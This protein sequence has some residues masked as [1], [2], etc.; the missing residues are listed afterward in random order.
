MTENYRR[1]SV[2]FVVTLFLVMGAIV[3]LADAQQNLKT[4]VTNAED[5]VY[6]TGALMI[7]DV[8]ARATPPRA[9][10]GAAYLTIRNIGPTDDVLI[11]VSSDIARKT[12]I[13]QS[14]LDGDIMKM[15]HV[16]KINVPANGQVVLKT[17]AQH[18]MFMGMKQP[19]TAGSSF[20]VVLVFEK[21]G[22]VAI[23]V[24]VRKNKTMQM[25]MKH[26]NMGH[27]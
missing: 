27:N 8:W 18:I 12:Q 7:S 2:C 3:P 19:L 16:R 10:T 13:H 26:Q 21:A 17:G 4:S 11:K 20:P 25:N 9:K 6:M 24:P 15:S 23:Q 1:A 14:R 22:K 5:N